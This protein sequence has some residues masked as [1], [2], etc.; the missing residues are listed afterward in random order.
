M[1][2]TK[3]TAP[4]LQ[5]LIVGLKLLLICAII[6]GIVSFVYALTQ[7]TYQANLQAQKATAVGNIFNAEVSTEALNADGTVNRVS[8]ADGKTLMGYSVEVVEPSGYGGDVTLMVGYNAERELIGIEIISHSE[9][10]GLGSKVE[11]PAFLDQFNGLSGEISY[12]EIDGI[13]GATY[14]SKAVTAGINRATAALAAA[15]EEGGGSK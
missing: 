2:K 9:T 1:E 14:S 6:A 10:P 8:S 5:A 7:E 4:A 15:L 12:G 11:D 3:Q 13:T